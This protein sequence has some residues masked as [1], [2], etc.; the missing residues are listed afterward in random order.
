M[1]TSRHLQSVLTMSRE[2]R[3][4]LLLFVGIAALFTYF[5]IRYPNLGG[6]DAGQPALQAPVLQVDCEAALLPAVERVARAYELESGVRVILNGVSDPK[7]MSDLVIRGGKDEPAAGGFSGVNQ[8]LVKTRSATGGDRVALQATVFSIADAQRLGACRFA[9]Y[10][11][12]RDR[13]LPIVVPDKAAIAEAD[14]W[15]EAPQPAVAIWQTAFPFLKSELERFKAN[16]GVRLRL[17]LGDC[18]FVAQ[19]AGESKTIDAVISLGD[20][21]GLGSG[22]SDWHPLRI[23]ERPIVLI[24]SRERKPLFAADRVEAASLRLGGVKG[25]QASILER[26]DSSALPPGLAKLLIEQTVAEY[27]GPQSLWRGVARHE[28]DGG[29]AAAW[30]EAQADS[31]IRIEPLRDESARLPVIFW[32]S[33]QSNHRQLLTRLAASMRQS[34][35]R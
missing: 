15:T 7:E 23:P 1:F 35:N 32:I 9:R 2:N 21:C 28:V 18:G 5:R 17:L 22:G 13:G 27:D 11:I 8:F 10:L 26:A 19:R 33:S 29:I 12:A 6:A 25:M 31:R 3:I 16:E 20:D 30:P 4:L 34:Q 24:T 14:S